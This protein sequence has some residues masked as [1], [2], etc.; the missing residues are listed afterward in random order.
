MERRESLFFRS[1]GTCYCLELG[2]LRSCLKLGKICLE[3]SQMKCSEKPEEA[4]LWYQKGQAKL[5][6]GISQDLK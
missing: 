6:S 2:W 3:P 5:V 1:P 4:E